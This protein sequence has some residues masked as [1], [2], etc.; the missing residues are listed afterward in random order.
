MK[1]PTPAT[2]RETRLL[3]LLESELIRR[4][5][6]E[7]TRNAVA[8]VTVRFLRSTAKSPRKLSRSDV[9]RFL[10][11]RAREDLASATRHADLVRL[12]ILFRALRA[13][14]QIDADPS[15]GLVVAPS[16]RRPVLALGEESITTLFQAAVLRLE[17]PRRRI[18]ALALRDRACL[19]L[20]YC[21]GLR[22]S[23]VAAAKVTDLD[24]IQGEL[25][26]RSAKRGDTRTLPV[27]PRSLPWMQRWLREGRPVLLRGPDRGQLLLDQFGKGLDAE[28]GVRVIVRNVARR[29]GIVA[30]PHALR[31]AVATHLVRRGVPVPAVQALLGHRQLDTTAMYVEV[32]RVELRRAVQHLDRSAAPPSPGC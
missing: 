7:A 9:E 8:W 28:I 14:G 15:Q 2:R 12:R 27:P 18:R 32:D 25:R 23:E 24:L 22:A 11:E 31:R 20:A 26:V 30:H 3:R 29:A 21:L 13:L 4:G 19:E 16:R 5:L 6:T 10:A 1:R 17:D